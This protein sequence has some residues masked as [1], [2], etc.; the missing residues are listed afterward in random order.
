ML[1]EIKICLTQSR[2]A[3][4]D[5]D[6]SI[7]NNS[8]FFPSFFFPLLFSSSSFLKNSQFIKVCEM[9]PETLNNLIDYKHLSDVITKEEGLAL[10]KKVRPGWEAR[11]KEMKD[12]GFPAYTTSAG[13]LGYP[14]DK[15]RALCKEYV[16]HKHPAHRR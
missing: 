13:W 11:V 14:E 6:R 10:L 16:E 8:P 7:T 2:D 15:I 4:D 9:E 1:S 3:N 5:D 12:D